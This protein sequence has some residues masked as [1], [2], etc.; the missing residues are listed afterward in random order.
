MTINMGWSDK[1]D[2]LNVDMK[3]L[4]ALLI[5]IGTEVN[6]ETSHR[7]PGYDSPGDICFID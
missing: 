6:S 5:E 1:K 3:A 7:A 4:G 2:R